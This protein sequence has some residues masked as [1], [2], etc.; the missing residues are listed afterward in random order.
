MMSHCSLFQSREENVLGYGGTS[1]FDH[2]KYFTLSYANGRGY[3]PNR[4]IFGDRLIPSEI[5]QSKSNFTYPT[6]VPLKVETH[7]S[8]DVAVYA[9]GPRSHLFSGS[10]E[11][12]VI[13]HI[14]AYAACIGNGL[15]ACYDETI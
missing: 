15:T 8:D 2:L 5:I 10:Y 4:N 9:S 6:T 11:Q 13:P 14:M 12:N 7:G 1:G 3:Y